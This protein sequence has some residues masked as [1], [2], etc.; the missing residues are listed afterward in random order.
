M[1]GGAESTGAE[2]GYSGIGHNPPPPRPPPGFDVKGSASL[3]GPCI[4]VW[5]KQLEGCVLTQSAG[6]HILEMR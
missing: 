6:G 5:G 2:V 1:A 4:V 3:D